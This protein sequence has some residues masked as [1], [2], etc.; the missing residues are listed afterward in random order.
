MSTDQRCPGHADLA[1]DLRHYA[2]RALKLLEPLVERIRQQPAD[3]NQPE[4]A[5][6]PPCPVCAV[7]TVLRGGRS[8][9]AVRLAD[10]AAE[11]LDVLRAALDE[12]AGVPVAG[13]AAPAVRPARPACAPMPSGSR[14]LRPD[15]ASRVQRIEVSRDGWRG[16]C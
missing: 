11:L 15:R 2:G 1:D 10:R 4:P 3:A 14:R 12:G 7:I 5:S 9:L 8:E 13:G 16:P 6:C